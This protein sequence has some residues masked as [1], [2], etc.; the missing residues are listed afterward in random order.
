MNKNTLKVAELKKL[1][2][3]M[4]TDELV[5]LI[6]ESYK[7]SKE[8]H[9]L[10]N[11][12]LMGDEGL[13]EVLEASKMK[14]KNEFFPKRGFGKLRV[15]IVKKAVSDVKNI[16]K[17]DGLILEIMIFSVEM[18]VEFINR[19]GDI[20][21]D[22]VDYMADTFDNIASLIN[23]KNK[24]ELFKRFQDRLRAIISDSEDVGCWGIHDSFEGSYS[25]LKWLEEC[26]DGESAVTAEDKWL[27]ISR[28]M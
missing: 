22:M 15:S 11:I 18:G 7:L 10:V 4:P 2:S 9:A 27:K 6:I 3:K 17:E 25:Y 24:Y 26:D 1:L 20:D 5:K 12:K 8:V 14:I 13:N 28:V 16:C 21:E 19:F 23:K